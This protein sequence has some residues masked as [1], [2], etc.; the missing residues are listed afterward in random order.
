MLTLAVGQV[1]VT[2]E[3]TDKNI[4]PLTSLSPS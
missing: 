4:N 2:P 3:V 1:N